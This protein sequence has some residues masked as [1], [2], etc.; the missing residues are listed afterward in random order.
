MAATTKDNTFTSNVVSEAASPLVAG[1]VSFNG[2]I[3]IFGL[4]G[5]NGVTSETEIGLMTVP[6]LNNWL[7]RLAINGYGTSGP[8]GAWAGEWWSVHNYLQYGGICIVG[9]TGSTGDYYSSTGVLTASNTP[10]HN[11]SL[12]NID[13]V[14]DSGITKSAEA[15]IS[16]ATT[17]QDCMAII[18]NYKKLTGV[19][20][21]NA[22]YSTKST[23]FGV[24]F[25]S[26]Y[27][28]YVA[29][30]KKFV[31]GVGNNVN[32]LE[33]NLS[34]DAAGCMART[35][36]DSFRWSS[37]A[38]K[39]RGRILGV[40]N[41]QQTFGE[42]DAAYIYAANINPVV[43]FPGE[44]TF[45]MGNKTSTTGTL[46][47]LNVSN[48]VIYIKNEILKITQKVLFEINDSITRQRVI[49]ESRPLLDSIRAGGGISN[50]RIV[51]DET[52]NTAQTIA[53]NKLIV[54]VYIQPT[55]SVE[56]IQVTIINTNSSQAF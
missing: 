1:M 34:P 2:L 42:T 52:N 22:T 25:E 36:R 56:T 53:E 50:Y 47:R 21:L 28:S 12:V 23:D 7:S 26:E 14:F 55:N 6:T 16:I 32:I 19:P 41:M 35:L 9:G 48:V 3:P 38:G 29:G 39:T 40:V 44:G 43:V 54:D 5:A 15:A 13:V 45:L 17:R 33:A 27:V 24:T 51:C 10:L 4:T 49:S 20:G 11:K 31:A 18:G 46:Q 8:T 30:R 37:P